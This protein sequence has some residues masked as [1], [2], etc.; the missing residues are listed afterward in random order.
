MGRGNPE[1]VYNRSMR[2][3]E[4]AQSP[5]AAEAAYR[6]RNGGLVG[7]QFFFFW[8]SLSKYWHLNLSHTY[9]YNAH[10]CIYAYQCILVLYYAKHSLITTMFSIILR[11]LP[12]A[13]VLRPAS[14]Q[15]TRPLP[16]PLSRAARPA[17]PAS[18]CRTSPRPA[19]PLRPPMMTKFLTDDTGCPANAFARSA[20][21]HYTYKLIGPE[22]WD[23]M[24]D[25]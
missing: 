16:R 18:R 11:S 21:M 3:Q 5:A 2:E 20:V 13:A 25:K 14:A 6:A 23:I 17:S 7:F 12:T 22:I 9:M 1:S 24:N 15:L 10:V 8:Q 19:I 4:P